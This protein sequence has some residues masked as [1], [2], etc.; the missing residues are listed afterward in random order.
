[1]KWAAACFSTMIF[2]VFYARD[3]YIRV[4]LQERPYIEWIKNKDYIRLLLFMIPLLIS[5]WLNLFILY[6]QHKIIFVLIN[7]GVMVYFTSYDF[8]Q[9]AYCTKTH[10]QFKSTF[11]QWFGFVVAII[12]AI[13]SMFNWIS[14][15]VLT[16]IYDEKINDNIVIYQ[17]FWFIFIAI[18]V[19]TSII[20]EINHFI[21]VYHNAFISESAVNP[22]IRSFCGMVSRPTFRFIH[23]INR[24]IIIII[25]L[26]FGY[27]YNYHIF[28]LIIYPLTIC[29]WNI[30]SFL[31]RTANRP[32]PRGCCLT[33]WKKYI[34]CLY[35]KAINRHLRI[36]PLFQAKEI[37]W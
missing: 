5:I 18:Y 12:G 13:I 3:T 11:R 25:W 1:M 2:I 27:N 29:I 15:I 16:V 36:N 26:I 14:F 9:T 31:Q 4:R 35:N 24:Y 17:L 28:Y 20:L 6:N 33:V 30:S 37:D 34:E 23:C 19:I 32:K 7:C 10:V 22:G 8:F 21:Y